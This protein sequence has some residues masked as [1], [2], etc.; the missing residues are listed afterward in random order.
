M[1]KA[2]V[3]LSSTKW[4]S[5][6]SLSLRIR[7]SNRPLDAKNAV[8]CSKQSLMK[9]GKKTSRS[10]KSQILSSLIVPLAKSV[11]PMRRRKSRSKIVMS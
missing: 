10:K 1:S 8:L 2:G 3:Q 9:R 4:T 5:L 7:K 11:D 6:Y